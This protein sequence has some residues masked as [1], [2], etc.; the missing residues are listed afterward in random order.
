VD[1]LDI[2]VWRATQACVTGWA[3]T[4]SY[5]GSYRPGLGRFYNYTF[6]LFAGFTADAD[7]EEGDCS[8][9]V[10]IDNVLEAG[11]VGCIISPCTSAAG[12]NSIRDDFLPGTSVECGNLGYCTVKGYGGSI[13]IHP[14]TCL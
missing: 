4:I 3:A 7:G 8:V 5:R 13:T 2:R 6:L 12:N 11:D 1:G 10:T 9:D 14:R